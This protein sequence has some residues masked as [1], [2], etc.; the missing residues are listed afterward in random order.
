V[1]TSKTRYF[2]DQVSWVKQL[3]VHMPRGGKRSLDMEFFPCVYSPT[4]AVWQ[5]IRDDIVRHSQEVFQGSVIADPPGYP[6]D[7]VKKDLLETKEGLMGVVRDGS[8]LIG[9]STVGWLRTSM[10]MSETLYLVFSSVS[11]Q[12]QGVGVSTFV[13]ATIISNIFKEKSMKEALLSLDTPNPVVLGLMAK[14]LRGIFPNPFRPGDQPNEEIRGLGKAI[15]AKMF[16]A[17]IFDDESFVVRERYLEYPGLIYL[18][19]KVPQHSDG[20]VNDFCN[21]HLRYDEKRGNKFIVIGTIESEIINAVLAS[22]ENA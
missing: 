15:A 9:F 11:P 12:Y 17:Q 6:Q 1:K 7:I 16:P 2:P 14:V 18:P 5:T 4:V 13:V 10:C 8:K 19:D 21:S 20:R 3:E 22:F